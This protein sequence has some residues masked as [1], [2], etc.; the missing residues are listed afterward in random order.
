MIWEKSAARLIL[1][2]ATADEASLML[3]DGLQRHRAAGHLY[4]PVEVRCWRGCCVR[5]GGG[6]ALCGTLL[7][8]SES[9]IKL[10]DRN[11]ERTVNRDF[12]SCFFQEV[13][14][15][16]GVKKNQSIFDHW[17]SMRETPLLLF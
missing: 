15:R 5:S 6:W 4:P 3:E 2:G 7:A 14:C 16:L 8:L 12:M 1:T 17:Q 10:A 9:Q 13:H 11:G